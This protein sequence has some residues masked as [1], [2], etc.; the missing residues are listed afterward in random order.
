[1]SDYHNE[2]TQQD[3]GDVLVGAPS[4]PRDVIRDVGQIEQIL[5]KATN[6]PE[7]AELS[8]QIKTRLGRW[9]PF[10]DEMPADLEGA[11]MDLYEKVV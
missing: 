9:D 7:L 4:L 11:V 6:F 5:D 3:D 10:K 2:W 8:N 1:M